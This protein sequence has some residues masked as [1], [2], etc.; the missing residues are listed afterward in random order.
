MQSSALKSPR[1][2]QTTVERSGGAARSCEQSC[3]SLGGGCAFSY[4]HG[5]HAHTGDSG[6]AG[7]RAPGADGLT[8]WA[9]LWRR[10]RALVPTEVNT[11]DSDGR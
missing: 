8:D 4:D 7:M 5:A 1:S 2:H 11:C 9:A 6:L 10:R 3:L